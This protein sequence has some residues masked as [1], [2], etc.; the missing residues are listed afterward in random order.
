MTS[1]QF[2]ALIIGAVVVERVFVIPGI[3]SLLIDS[4]S[5]RD[6]LAVQGVVVVLVGITLVLNLVV[7]LLYTVIDP[8][9]RHAA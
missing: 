6:M 9:I 8:R 3:G 4:I 1:V 7:D 5:N 2:A